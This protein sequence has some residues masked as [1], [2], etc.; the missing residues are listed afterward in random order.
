MAFD[1]TTFFSIPHPVH[2]L[3]VV[4]VGV[5]LAMLWFLLICRKRRLPLPVAA[6][7]LFLA[8]IMGFL[9]GRL[10]YLLVEV[11]DI[12]AALGM[13]FQIEDVREMGF[14]GVLLGVL[15]GFYLS[16]K[17][18]RT[19]GLSAALAAPGLMLVLVARLA[20]C[21]VP[22]G[23]GSYVAVPFLRF[24]PV[25]M[26]DGFGD[27]VLSVYLLEALWALACLLYLLRRKKSP[28]TMDLPLAT[29][30]F[31]LGQIYL[32]SLRAE[33]LKYGFIRVSQLLAMV[34]LVVVLIYCARLLKG[35][36]PRGTFARRFSLFALCVVLY[37]LAEFGLDRLP[38]PNI[39]IRLLML[40]PTALIGSVVLGSVFDAERVKIN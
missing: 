22:F 7:A 14:V 39:I 2:Y 23:T 33:G 28:S 13:L 35:R 18:Y 16:E 12:G 3:V 36:L 17:V 21:F 31:A 25:A 8:S 29:A 30:L 24:F 26:P 10:L 40:L 1:V 5:V 34:M 19:A 38:W 27:W 32:E 20:E 15:L 6:A 4:G 11:G 37:I 9:G